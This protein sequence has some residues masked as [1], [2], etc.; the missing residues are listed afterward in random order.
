MV[1]AEWIELLKGDPYRLYSGLR[2][3]A[4]L[5]MGA[6]GGAVVV[7]S[8]YDD[9]R[10]VLCDTEGFSSAPMRAA[11][12]VILG[13]DPPAHARARSILQRALAP[14][15]HP[16]AA[17]TIRALAA[18]RVTAMARRRRPDVVCDLAAPL[19]LEVLA[20]LLGLPRSRTGAARRW[21]EA[22]MW[23]SLGQVTEAR[24]AALAEA[25]AFLGRILLSRTQRPRDDLLSA[26]VAMGSARARSV[27][28]L[29]LVAGTETTTH[30]I[31]NAVVALLRRPELL[32]RAR[33][34]PRAL[35]RVID[36]VLRHESPVQFVQRLSR[37]ATVVGGATVPAGAQVM[38]LLGA[39]NR[40][41]ARFQRAAELSPARAR[42][43]HLA[44]GA[45]PHRC[46][47]AWLARREAAIAIGALLD[48]APDLRA[49]QALDALPQVPWPQLRG[50]STLP[51]HFACGA[52]RS[53]GADGREPWRAH[54]RQPRRR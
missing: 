12:P 53:A 34:S 8:R 35:A 50:P 44:F 29:L 49:A 25:D 1:L 38:V 31:G 32:A 39:A 41:D 11:D 3:A 46:P 48:A 10:R 15:R 47:G 33:R 20:R 6:P 52:V 42:R 30:L 23:S 4:P 36:E 43:E 37:R 24:A 40:D 9:A 18:A 51:V 16:S 19:P 27:A 22:M 13:A 7:V 26:L 14:A 21:A 5:V 28:R 54:A 45:G 17:E 2:A